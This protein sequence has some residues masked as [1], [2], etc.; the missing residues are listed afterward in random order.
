MKYLGL[1][2]RKTEEAIA[3]ALPTKFALLYDGW[4]SA[5]T[6]YFGIMASVTAA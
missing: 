2:T 3:K 1:V 5:S 4:S 6:H